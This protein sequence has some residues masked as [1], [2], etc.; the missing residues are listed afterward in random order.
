MLNSQQFDTITIQTDN[1]NWE[2]LMLKNGVNLFYRTDNYSISIDETTTW[3]DIDKLIRIFNRELK[4]EVQLEKT[5][6]VV[7]NMHRKDSF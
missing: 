6:Y 3:S 4:T 1:E 5:N 2:N 7:S